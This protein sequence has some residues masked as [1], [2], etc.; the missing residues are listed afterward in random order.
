MRI[1]RVAIALVM[2]AL[3][4][5]PAM[6]G[7]MKPQF[8]VGAGF[9][10]WLEDGAP[11]GSVGFQGGVLFK[12]HPQFAVGGELG[13]QMLGKNS[14]QESYGG[15]Y[16]EVESKYSVIPVTAQGYWLIPV[17]GTMQPMISVGLGVYNFR[18]KADVKTN[19]PGVGSLLEGIG[20]DDSETK[21]GF[22]FGAG[23][24]FGE[25]TAKIKYGVDGKFHIIS[26]EGEST[27][28]IQIMARAYFG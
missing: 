9:G 5:L 12:V 17:E 16:A 26:T 22:N 24:R 21:A 28:V 18:W 10:K 4:A 6:A 14:V 27:N 23:V 19:V 11:G 25:P 2:M 20:G 13:Y 8:F 15:Y 7:E 1:G 3:L